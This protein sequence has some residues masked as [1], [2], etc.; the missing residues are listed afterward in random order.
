MMTYSISNK[1]RFDPMLV[2]VLS[3]ILVGTIFNSGTELI[4][5]VADPLS[6]LPDI[7]FWLMGS[8]D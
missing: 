3:G 5:F 7:T 6:K 8:L 2:L 1:I 4:K